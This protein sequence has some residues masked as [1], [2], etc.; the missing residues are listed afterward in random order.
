M[1]SRIEAY[2]SYFAELLDALK[3]ARP[4]ITRANKTQP[5]SWFNF[6]SRQRFILFGWDF[7]EADRFRV[8]VWIGTPDPDRNV[9][10]FEQ[11]YEQRDQIQSR[12]NSP[13]TW[14]RM[15]GY[16]SKRVASYAP[17]DVNVE[18]PSATLLQLKQ[19]FVPTMLEFVDAFGPAIR[20]LS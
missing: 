9:E 7:C 2:Q 6:G 11:F 13:V 16:K 20:S 15:P 3:A 8:T 4:G 14:E 10:I 1:A 17:L 12:I 18:S 5:H 19:W